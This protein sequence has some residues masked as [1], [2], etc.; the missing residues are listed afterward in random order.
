ME[1]AGLTALYSAVGCVEDV[2][3]SR[4]ATIPP[5]KLGIDALPP[6][7][8]NLPAWDRFPSFPIGIPQPIGLPEMF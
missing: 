8:R 6:G 5:D 2:I 1:C 3:F 7:R 4:D